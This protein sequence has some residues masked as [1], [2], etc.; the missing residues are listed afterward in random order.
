LSEHARVLLD[1][2]YERKGVKWLDVFRAF[3]S[4]TPH[5]H[6]RATHQTRLGLCH[7]MVGRCR[8][9]SQADCL[10]LVLD[11][12]NTHVFS[13]LY[14]TFEPAEANRIRKRLQLHYMPKHG[15]WLNMAEIELSVFSRQACA[16][17]I[18]DEAALQRR[19]TALEHQRNA[20]HLT[21][22]WRFTSQ[23]ARLKLQRLYPSISS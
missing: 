6:Q 3:D 19:V 2:E 8:L 14:E 4:P 23:Q 17:Y 21:V 5:P 10:R 9:S 15:S 13:S 20:Q 11:N 12:L 18:P 16:G 1:H 22:N 7:A